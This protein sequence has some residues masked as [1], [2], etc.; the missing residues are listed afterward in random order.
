MKIK[1]FLV[2]I[3]IISIRGSAQITFQRG[4]GGTGG[5]SGYSVQQTTDGGY[6]VTGVINSFGAGYSNVYLMKTDSTGDTLWTRTYG[7]TLADDGYSVLQT[8]D[9]GYII[10]GRTLSFGTGGYD[11]YLI[12]TDTSGN[13]LWSKAIGGTNQDEG[14]SVQQTSDSAYIITGFTYSGNSNHVFLI[15]TDTI[16]Q[17][18]WKKS[19]GGTGSDEGTSV[20]Q[21]SDS[22]Y[23]ITGNTSSFGAGQTDVYLFKTDTTGN[24]IWAKSYGGTDYDY[25][26]CVLQTADGGYI[27]SG[28][29]F[30]FGSGQSDVYIIRADSSGNLIWSK[31]YGG[32]GFEGGN[33]IQQTSDGGYIVAGYTSSFGSGDDD[34]YL[35]KIDANGDS[36]WTKTF[37][38]VSIDR[39]NSIQQTADGGYIIIG[40][41]TSQTGIY[42]IKTD[43]LG[44]SGCNE[45]GTA[46][47]VTTP[48]TQVSIIS[49]FSFITSAIETTPLSFVGSGGFMNTLFTN[50][51]INEPII[52]NYFFVSP[53]PSTGKITVY[54]EGIIAKGN[55]EIVNIL[56]E[57]VLSKNFINESNEKIELNN[58]P[59][60]IY[61]VKVFDGERSH[62][63]KLVIEHE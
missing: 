55:V 7:G 26:N 57:T 22:G 54:F 63:E 11:V 17:V 28:N 41:T 51:V 9:E 46:T 18:L 37:G 30:S 23:V 44:N 29:T 16:G 36:L 45:G 60:G 27:I 14:H 39:G 50:V 5:D 24:T 56:G 2:L 35:I 1:V 31:A 62:C 15:R 58:V 48:A 52:N 34:I 47:L 12:R 21:T 19:F 40:E 49:L 43:S 42:L 6:I 61:F 53:N 33:T 20:R 32:T 3:S 13:L 8:V 38:G 25:G 4:I 59:T 10:T